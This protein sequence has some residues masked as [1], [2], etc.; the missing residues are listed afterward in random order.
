MKYIIL[1]ILLALPY[2]ACADCII[3]DYSEK[4]E[5]VCFGYNP[6]APPSKKHGT[7]STRMKMSKKSRIADGEGVTTAVGMTDEELMFMHAS[8]RQDGY[9]GKPKRREHTARN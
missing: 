2:S 8:N 3:T 4:F 9:R 5:I 6:T 1:V 7:S